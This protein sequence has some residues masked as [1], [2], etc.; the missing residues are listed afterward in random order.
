MW[1]RLSRQHRVSEN[2]LTREIQLQTT[3][4]KAYQNVPHEL[5]TLKNYSYAYSSLSLAWQVLRHQD[6]DP[7]IADNYRRQAL[8]HSLRIGFEPK[9][10]QVS[11]AVLTMRCLKSD[12]YRRLIELLQAFRN[13]LQ[14][15]FK[16]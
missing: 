4:E 3:I 2:W 1:I 8:E 5:L 14:I 16:S 9:F 7:V 12:R 11:L 10:L 13:G 15:I 6:T